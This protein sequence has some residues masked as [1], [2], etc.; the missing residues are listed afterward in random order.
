M[1]VINTTSEHSAQ[2]SQFD[3]LCNGCGKKLTVDGKETTRAKYDC[4]EVY[5]GQAAEIA[6]NITKKEDETESSNLNKTTIENFLEAIHK[7]APQYFFRSLELIDVD[8]DHETKT[9]TT[10]PCLTGDELLKMAKHGEKISAPKATIEA[11]LEK[12]DLS[13][14]ILA[15]EKT[16]QVDAQGGIIHYVFPLDHAASYAVR[17]CCPACGTPLY[18][19]VGMYPEIRI[20]VVGTPR[21]GKS[22]VLTATVDTFLHGK[23]GIHMAEDKSNPKYKDFE[24]NYLARYRSN[25]SIQKTG[26]D[27]TLTYRFTITVGGKKVNLLFIDIAGELLQDA[28]RGEFHKRYGMFMESVDCFWLCT[29][30]FQIRQLEQAPA[31][32]GLGTRMNITNIQQNA[33]ELGNMLHILT[34]GK[35]TDGKKCNIPCA[36][37]LVKSDHLPQQDRKKIYEGI[38]QIDNLYCYTCLGGDAIDEKEFVQM[39]YRVENYIHSRNKWMIECY[40]EYFNYIG[41]MA[42][43]AYGHAVAKFNVAFGEESILLYIPGTIDDDPLFEEGKNYE[44]EVHMGDMLTAE[45]QREVNENGRR[46]RNCQVSKARLRRGNEIDTHEILAVRIPVDMGEHDKAILRI[47]ETASQEQNVTQGEQGNNEYF[48]SKLEHTEQVFLQ[49]GESTEEL[50]EVTDKPAPDQVAMPLIWSMAML[51]YYDTIGEKQGKRTWWQWLLGKDAEIVST[52][53]IKGDSDS[54]KVLCGLKKTHD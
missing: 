2:S 52:G 43:S 33:N 21:Q 7:D 47:F 34:N 37:L 20:G 26:E 38:K 29:D 50:F 36:V 31:E 40:Q 19:K 4:Y 13:S 3:F 53:F 1:P 5:K 24:K 28:L 15:G 41:Y 12:E 45:T 46:Y 39:R 23:Y 6:K 10:V 25:I 42:C 32:L 22:A 48:I 14:A 44:I 8:D 11:L 16:M 17:Y 54:R 49:T 30:D 18:G 51:G 9:G 27:Q 35:M